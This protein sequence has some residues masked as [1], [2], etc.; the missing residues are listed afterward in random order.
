MSAAPIESV[1]D[2]SPSWDI[3]HKKGKQNSFGDE[4]ANLNTIIGLL[5]HEFFYTVR[6]TEK[7]ANK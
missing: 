3:S 7:S 2:M 4:L 1:D 6:K 5:L